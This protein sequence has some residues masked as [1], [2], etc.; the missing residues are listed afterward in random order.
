MSRIWLISSASPPASQPAPGAPSHE[1]LSPTRSAAQ[2]RPQSPQPW[3]VNHD[4][5]KIIPKSASRPWSSPVPFPNHSRRPD[6][7]LPSIGKY[8]LNPRHYQ[9]R[10]RHLNR[11]IG[12]HQHYRRTNNLHPAIQYPV[13]MKTVGHSFLATAPLSRFLTHKL[14]GL[15]RM[16]LASL[17]P[18]MMRLAMLVA[19]RSKR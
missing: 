17:F 12:R 2:C 15:P 16:T 7:R 4:A 18:P 1:I 19:V 6:H 3:L 8:H 10:P 11:H 13:H 5:S 9:N 14:G